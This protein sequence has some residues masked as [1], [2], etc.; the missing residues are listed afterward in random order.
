MI[1]KY[2]IN[3]N[4]QK[5][6]LKDFNPEDTHKLSKKD[7]KKEY[8]QLQ[9][10]FSDLQEVLYASKKYA[11]LIIL[12]GMDCSGK[13][14]TVKKALSSVNPN[15]FFV[16]SFKQ[17]TP[18]ELGHDYLWRIHKE[19]PM[20]G[21]IVVFNRSYY[22]DVLVTRVHKTI[23][24]S[25]AFRRFR[26]INAFEKY[27]VDNH[28]LVLKFF[29]HISKDFQQ[30]KL[31][32]RVETPEKRWKFSDTD[33]TERKFWDN[34]QECYADVLSNCSS[35]EAP[36]YVIPGNH[37]WFRDYLILKTIVKNLEDLKL[38]YPIIE[39]SVQQ[40]IQEVKDSKGK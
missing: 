23:D 37:R 19:T 30:K 4:N 22:E 21:N 40:L 25:I 18:A 11:L 34:Y 6:N 8:R 32:S 10:K 31:L 35:K 29:L 26:E 9:K 39:G 7:I 15:G 5:V 12:Q 13:D 33:L 16:E 1:K 2:R 17:P 24:D 3:S 38:E 28:T 27:L 14:G 20:K 36:W